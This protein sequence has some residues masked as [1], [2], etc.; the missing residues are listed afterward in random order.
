[1]SVNNS[2]SHPNAKRADGFNTFIACL[3]DLSKKAT[4]KDVCGFSSN[5][6]YEKIECE[7]FCDCLTFLPYTSHFFSAFIKLSENSFSIFDSTNL[8]DI[9][10][11]PIY[12]TFS[13]ENKLRSDE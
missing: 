5:I 10:N 13:S 7:F 6:A 11:V 2:L 9:S 3:N 4:D 1:M 12:G 8:V